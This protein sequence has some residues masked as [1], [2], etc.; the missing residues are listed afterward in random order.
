V[1]GFYVNVL[2]GA[3]ISAKVGPAHCSPA[4]FV[5]KQCAAGA[6]ASPTLAKMSKRKIKKAPVTTIAPYGIRTCASFCKRIFW[7]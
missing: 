4:S 6:G 1:R 7:V 5:A 2:F 3:N